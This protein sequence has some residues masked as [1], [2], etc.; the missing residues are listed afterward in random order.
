MYFWAGL[1]HGRWYVLKCIFCV[2]SPQ[3]HPKIMWF[4]GECRKF[5]TASR[6]NTV[7]AFCM[8]DNEG[9]RHALRICN[10]ILTAF[11]RQQLLRERSPVLNVYTYVACLV[12]YQ[13][14]CFSLNDLPR[15]TTERVELWKPFR[16]TVRVRER[17]LVYWWLILDSAVFTFRIWKFNGLDRFWSLL[18]VPRLMAF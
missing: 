15:T 13:S 9:Y 18:C 16:V 17:F 1:M 5:C 14:A 7:H 11:P 12:Y 2:Q 3:P 4:M 8:L 10:K 6:Y